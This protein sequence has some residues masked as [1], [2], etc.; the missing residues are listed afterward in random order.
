[1]LKSDQ[2]VRLYEDLAYLHDRQGHGKLRDCFLM[3]AADAACTAGWVDVAERIR[4]QLLS[5]NPH[6]LLRPYV[7]FADALRSPDIQSYLEDLRATH[8]P[9]LAGREL[10]QA[11]QGDE[12]PFES[13]PSPEPVKKMTAA[14]SSVNK[15]SDLRPFP[16]KAPPEETRPVVPSTPPP[17]RVSPT[18][19][20]SAR[21]GT[22][23][24]RNKAAVADRNHRTGAAP[25][26]P[27]PL[28]PSEEEAPSAA[29]R[30][31]TGLLFA[32]LLLAGL[33]LAG[34]TL[35]LPLLPTAWLGH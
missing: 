22:S 9:E 8:P 1:M 30:W 10:Q 13:E 3:L 24:A 16:F 20:R 17:V 5:F 32:L 12:S 11:A 6:H 14:A 21:G 34:Y 26:L 31:F 33:T 28:F 29:S 25:S 19:S 18:V 7:S 4:M 27:A 35:L 15:G 2:V 23:A